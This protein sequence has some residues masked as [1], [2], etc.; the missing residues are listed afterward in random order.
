MDILQ[1]PKFKYFLKSKPRKKNTK[2]KYTKD[3]QHYINSTK[4]TPTELIQE[5]REEQIKYPWMD[6]RSLPGYFD[7]FI[8]FLEKR[9]ITKYS[10]KITIDS[11]KTFYHCFEIKTPAKTVLGVPEN[12][13][14]LYEDLPQH[15]AIRRIISLSNVQYRALF[16]FMASSAMNY[17]DATSINVSELI[18]AINY[19]FKIRKQKFKVDGLDELYEINE[20]VKGITPVW[21]MWRFKTNK[22]HITFSSPESFN[23]IIDYFKDQ[24]PA[25]EDVP[26]FRAYKQQRKTEYRAVAKYLHSMNK[27]LWGDKKVGKFAFVTSK[28]FRTFFANEMEDAEVYYK[29]IR[30]MMGHKQAGVTQNYFKSNAAK[31]LKS[32]LKGVHRLTFL[33]EV[34]VIDNTDEKLLA[35]EEENRQMKKDLEHFKKMIHDKEKQEKLP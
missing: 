20:K 12:Y 29:H 25:D 30:L 15:D 13:Y 10:Q 34:T 1:D 26:I 22:Q 5:A 11:V 31:M 24:P 9:G 2:L 28:S 6:E 14:I 21:R 18:S 4:K 35:L 33:E 32:Y 17:S 16:S 7:D 19:Y 8:I 3:I 23:F 27:K